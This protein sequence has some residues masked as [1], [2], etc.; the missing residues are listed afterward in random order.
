MKRS[1][2]VLVVLPVLQAAAAA[3]VPPPPPPPGDYGTTGYGAPA[4]GFHEHDGFY[5][6]LDIGFG[7]T[8]MS[9]KDLD[10]DISGP[11]G[12]FGIAIGGAVAQDLIVY[13]EVF[14]DIAVN[15]DVRVGSFTGTT[16]D[17]SAGV[18]GIGGGLAY[19]FMPSNIYLS[20]TLAASRLTAQRHGS[21]V[22]HSAWGGGL[23]LMV[24]K[25]WWVSDNWGLGVAIQ[26][27]GGRIRDDSESSPTWDV[28][29]IAV[30]FSA[31]Y[32]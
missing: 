23:S 8:A 12:A 18:V 1:L 29:A 25:E 14:D 9:S 31:T 6:R 17:T 10:V 20:A 22:A 27:Y 30:V 5:L 3:Q 21:E 19:Y 26:L 15:P 11:G 16:S 4:P 7:G 2:L 24:G 28:G 32:N 13:G